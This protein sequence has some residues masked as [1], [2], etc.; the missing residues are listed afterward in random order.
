MRFARPARSCP[1]AARTF[2]TAGCSA[3]EERFQGANTPAFGLQSGRRGD[4][5]MAAPRSTFLICEV[6]FC[7][8][9]T[10]LQGETQTGHRERTLPVPRLEIQ[11]VV[12]KQMS[13]E[14]INMQ[15]DRKSTPLNSRHI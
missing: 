13:S 9:W 12:I 10:T 11:L 3:M 8:A 14:A 2:P 4:P 6:C 15:P 7:V 1:L 5:G